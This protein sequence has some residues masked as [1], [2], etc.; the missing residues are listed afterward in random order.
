MEKF[1]SIMGG[2]G[3]LAT[4]SFIHLLNKRTTAHKDQDYFNYVLFNHASIPDRTAFILDHKNE[5]P[6]PYL[7]SDIK[8]QTQ[9]G[10]AFIVLSCNTVHYFYDEMQK[11]TPIPILHMPKETLAVVKS[12]YAGKKV[13]FL[14]T[15][16]SIKAGI[17]QNEI[18][19]A[20]YEVWLPP[21][22][23]QAKITQLIYHDIKEEGFL[24]EALYVEIL[25]E[26]HEKYQQQAII[27]GC[28]ELSLMEEKTAH[29]YP[30]FDAQAILVDKTVALAQALKQNLQDV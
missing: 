23:L 16:G 3:T 12:R 7:L 28:T 4:E 20:G 26:V 9:L 25:K 8:M 18:E 2:M 14:G 29:T 24:N 17:Y 30:V 21:Q 5:N 10:S 11:A 22:T 15:E 1:F 13:A 6:L 19:N 27:L